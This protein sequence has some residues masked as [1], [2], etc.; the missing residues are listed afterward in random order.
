MKE[1]DYIVSKVSRRALDPRKPLFQLSHALS[2]LP[3]CVNVT[4]WTFHLSGG[5]DG[6]M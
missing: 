2:V 6:G 5:K 1:K 4:S 3:P